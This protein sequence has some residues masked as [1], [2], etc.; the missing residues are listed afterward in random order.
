[1]S[2]LEC[3]PHGAS[4]TAFA[5]GVIFYLGQCLQKYISLQGM[6]DCHT[7][8]HVHTYVYVCVIMMF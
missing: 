2:N 5:A 8:A 7:F 6:Y 1:M 4:I 3:L